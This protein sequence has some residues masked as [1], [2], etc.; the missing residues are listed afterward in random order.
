MADNNPLHLI[1]GPNISTIN[2]V[3]HPNDRGIFG[4]TSVIPGRDVPHRILHLQ[5]GFGQDILFAII[6]H[7]ALIIIL[8]LV[9]VEGHLRLYIQVVAVIAFRLLAY[10]RGEQHYHN[11]Q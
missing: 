9:Q 7:R 6:R 8:T 3:T 10:T 1:I 2:A 5:D 11:G 4:L